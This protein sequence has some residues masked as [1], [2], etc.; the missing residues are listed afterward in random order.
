M[1]TKGI[2]ESNLCWCENWNE[3]VV[4]IFSLLKITTREIY[5]C[6]DNW[7]EIFYQPMCSVHFFLRP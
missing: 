6:F 3:I 1:Q 4:N 7:A 2:A 5:G